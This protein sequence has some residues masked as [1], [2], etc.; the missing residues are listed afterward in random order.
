MKHIYLYVAPTIGLHLLI[1]SLSSLRLLIGVAIPVLLLPTILI[2]P[3]SWSDMLSRLFPFQRG[4]AHT[5]WA[6]NIWALV[7]PFS[8]QGTRGIAGDVLPFI[9]P[10]VT[11][12]LTV[13]YQT[14]SHVKLSCYSQLNNLKPALMTLYWDNSAVQCHLVFIQSALSSFLLG[15]HVHEKA[16]MLAIVPLRYDESTQ[17]K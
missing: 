12:L 11:F 16:I 15:W 5:Y 9:T 3:F 14:V 2:F 13:L 8:G 4:L 1:R 17:V 7:L 10:K 6:P